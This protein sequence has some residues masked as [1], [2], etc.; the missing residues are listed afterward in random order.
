MTQPSLPAPPSPA[1]LG[2]RLAPLALDALLLLAL[3]GFGA[4][5]MPAAITGAGEGLPFWA[6]SHDLVLDGPDAG[7]WAANATH[8]LRGDW[9]ALDMH[10]MPTWLMATALTML[11]V[12]DVAMAGHLVNHL[13]MLGLPLVIYGLGRAGGGPA[14]G[15]AAGATVAACAPLILASRRYG[16]DPLVASLLPLALLAALPARRHL[17]WAPA[18]GAVAAL[19]S[20]SH[21]TALPYLLPPLLLLALSGPR[22]WRRPAALLL[23]AAGAAATLWLVTRTFPLPTLDELRVS[24]S[25]GVAKGE[26]VGDAGL[27]QAAEQTLVA[28]AVDAL[29]QALSAGL[30]PL[31]PWWLSWSLML[32]APWVGA[33][34]LGLGRCEAGSPG[35]RGRLRAAL[36]WPDLGLGLAL[37]SCLAPLPVLAAAGAEPR[38]SVNLLPFVAVLVVRGLVSPFALAE[39][40]L[41]LRWPRWPKGLLALIPAWTLCWTAWHVSAASRVPPL[42]PLGQLMAARELGERIAE[43]APGPGG[44]ASP[45]RE[46]AAHAGRDFCPQTACPFGRTEADFLACVELLD[47]QCPGEGPIPYVV[48]ER[49][50]GPIGANEAAMGAWARARWGTAATVQRGPLKAHLVFIPRE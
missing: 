14:T 29:P 20:L 5:L 28:G 19:A 18:A 30:G 47:A 32:A 38:Y 33:L 46:A 43:G 22:G 1:A 12:P 15:L 45:L 16:V 26:A 40:A 7:E 13:A 34:G 36:S 25:E 6:T 10:R 27:S 35:W 8:A 42:P 4:S 50:D 23:Y 24:V 49:W 17:S 31:W 44:A 3:L 41:R 11:R 39:G 37:L 9:A 2:R 48:M 21:F